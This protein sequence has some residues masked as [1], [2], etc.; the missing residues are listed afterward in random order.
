MYDGKVQLKAINQSFYINLGIL[1]PAFNTI[2]SNQPA[3]T[4]SGRV[5]RPRNNSI[6]SAADENCEE[7]L[8]NAFNH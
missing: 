3:S 1:G 2:L 5:T 8:L 4:R 6:R 7:T